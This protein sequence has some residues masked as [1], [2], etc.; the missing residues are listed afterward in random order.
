MPA[1]I[2]K[3]YRSSL[4]LDAMRSFYDMLR[5][6]VRCIRRNVA[7]EYKPFLPFILIG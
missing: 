7:P 5:I 1:E 2:E 3:H 4:A 6:K